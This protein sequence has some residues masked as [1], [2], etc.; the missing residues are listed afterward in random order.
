LEGSFYM[1]NQ[2]L[3]DTDW[4]SMAHSIEVRVPFVDVPFWKTAAREAVAGRPS[5]KRDLAAALSPPLP[6]ELLDRPKSGFSIPVREWLMA[7]QSEAPV[8]PVAR[9][10][11]RRW[12]RTVY[13]KFVE[14]KVQ[15]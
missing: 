8:S 11:L 4:A 12:A 2:L 7:G 5:G 15:G 6:P 1:R 13:A 3:R 9:R 10:G 14:G